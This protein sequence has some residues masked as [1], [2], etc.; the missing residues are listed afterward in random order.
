MSHSS[1]L[2]VMIQTLAERC[3]WLDKVAPTL[4]TLSGG[5]LNPLICNREIYH[6]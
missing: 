4:G 5:P 3:M 6:E 2:H 1:R